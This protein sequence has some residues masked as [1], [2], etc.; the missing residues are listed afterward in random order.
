[1][2]SQAVTFFT[3]GNETTSIAMAFMLYE[4][5]IHPEIQE[6]LREEV[7]GVFEKYGT[8]SYEHL[9][10]LKYMEMVMKGEQTNKLLGLLGA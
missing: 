9:N 8:V 2:T 1:M 10:E 4:I 6:R 3:A 5:T 7:D